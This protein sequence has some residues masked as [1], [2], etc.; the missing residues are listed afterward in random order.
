MYVTVRSVFP[1]SAT[2][3]APPSIQLR[4]MMLLP[5]SLRNLKSRAPHATVASR[6]VG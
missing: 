3:S 5:V 2:V 6:P 4:I 1:T